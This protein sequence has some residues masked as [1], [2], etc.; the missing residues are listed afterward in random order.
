MAIGSGNLIPG[1]A[2]YV[3]HQGLVEMEID[4]H[5]TRIRWVHARGQHQ[6][7]GQ[8]ARGAKFARQGTIVEQKHQVDARHMC[9]DILFKDDI[10]GDNMDINGSEGAGQ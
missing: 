5:S 3:G 8:L 4:G 6:T 1:G 10:L 9:P 2:P 7:G